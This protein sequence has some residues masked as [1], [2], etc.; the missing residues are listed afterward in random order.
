MSSQQYT[1]LAQS[2]FASPY[3]AGDSSITLQSGEKFT[4]S[5]ILREVVQLQ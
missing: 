5:K 4:S 1:N 2:S 3:T